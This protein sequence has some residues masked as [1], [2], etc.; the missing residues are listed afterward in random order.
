[1]KDLKRFKIAGSD[2]K[3]F[4]LA[5]HGLQTSIT[6]GTIDLRQIGRVT[7]GFARVRCIVFTDFKT[8]QVLVFLFLLLGLTPVFAQEGAAASDEEEKKEEAVEAETEPETMMEALVVIGN[9]AKPLLE[10]STPVT[11]VDALELEKAAPRTVADALLNIPSLQTNNALGNTNNDFRFRGIGAGGT[12]FLE[13]EEDGIPITRDA[14]DFLYRITNTATA[15]VDTI[16]GGNAPILR[17]AAIGAVVNFRYKEGSRLEQQGDVYV[18]SSDFGMRRTELWLGGPINDR[19]TYTLSG[20]YTTDDGVREVDFPAND[21]TNIHGS[22]KYHFADDSGYVKVT[23]RNFNEANIVYLGTP[24]TGDL[25][26]P[27]A[28]PG[29]PDVT[30]GSILSREIALSTSFRAPG[31]PSRLDLTDGND[32]KMSYYGTEVKKTWQ[33]DSGL[34]IDFISR[35][36]YTDVSSGFSGYYSA[37][38]ALGGDFQTGETLVPNMLN[39]NTMGAGLVTYSYAM[40]NGFTPTGYT[41]TNQQGDVLDLGNIADA[42]GDGIIEIG[43]VSSTATALANGNGIF[44]PI[45]AFNQQNPQTSFQQDLELSFTWATD[46]AAHY[47]SFGYYCLDYQREQDNRQQLMLVDLKQ[48]ASRVDV[49]LIDADGNQVTLTDDGFLTHNH[50]LNRDR[51]DTQI[52]AFYG[53]Y[54]YIRDDLTLDVGLRYDVFS[55]VRLFN[56]TVNFYGDGPN[57]TP[58]PEPGTTASPALTSIQRYDGSFLTDFDYTTREMSYTV[59]ANYL[60]RE[61]AGVYGRYTR[62]QL[63]AINGASPTDVI[64]LGAR[65][66]GDRFGIAANLFDMVQEGDVQ[67]RGINIDGENVVVRL[68]TDRQSTGLELEGYYDVNDNLSFTMTGTYQ[69]PEFASGGSGTLVPGS[70]ISQA[71]LDAA[72]ADLTAIDGNQIANQPET[73]LNLGFEYSFELGDLGTLTFVTNSRYVGKAPVNDNNTRFFE[74][75]TKLNSGLNF[76]SAGG[77]WYARLNVHN[78]TDEDAILRLE[79]GSI[80]TSLTGGDIGSDGFFGRSL[81]GRNIVFGAGYRF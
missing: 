65:Y 4:F 75:Y 17:T 60:L 58:L 61:N 19:M 23:T 32:S 20:Y 21:G 62:G 51:I 7:I 37:G 74:S 29:G 12:Q 69:Q 15:G 3:Y 14:P 35:N 11:V 54:E 57:Q 78:L 31:D 40:P 24:L 45:A 81:Q 44:L 56:P 36:R 49:N 30:M 50:W 55:D 66:Q 39:S 52:D 70:N 73:L 72:L 27:Q 1:M 76:Q 46:T 28:F 80:N 34:I 79:G 9:R 6:N 10:T 2:A 38:F 22:L 47:A 68:Q 64:E 41:V 42:N 53:N 48:Q 16:R 13:F 77:D 59:G 33:K 71:E 5:E 67:D 63:P 26:N 8:F 18:Q 25:E 43:E